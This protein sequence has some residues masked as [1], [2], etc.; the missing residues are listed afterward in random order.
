MIVGTLERQVLQERNGHQV[1]QTTR[2][3]VE[4]SCRLH[5][6]TNRKNRIPCFELRLDFE[7]MKGGRP[8]N[9]TG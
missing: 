6:G 5:A 4:Y 7:P 3:M 2:V 8:A 1:E 9:W